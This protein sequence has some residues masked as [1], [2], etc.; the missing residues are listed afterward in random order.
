MSRVV[1]LCPGRGSYSK[2][3]L[4]CLTDIESNKLDVADAVRRSSG[5]PTVR[6]MDA[7]AKFRSS[8]HIAGENASLLTAGISGADFDQIHSKFDIVGICGNSMGW[9][10]ALGLANACSFKTAANLIETM[11]QYQ[12]RNVIGGQMVYSLVNDDWTVNLERIELVNQLVEEIPDCHWSIRLGGQAILGGTKEAL[13]RL[14]NALPPVEQSGRT[15]PFILPLHSAFHTPLML[16][17]HRQA[18]TDLADLELTTP[19]IPLIDGRGHI[20]RPKACDRHALKSY[21]LGKQVTE[22]YDFTAMMQSVLKH[23]APDHIILLGPGSNLGGAVAHVLIQERWQ[24]IRN[25]MDFIKRQQE[26]PFILAMGRPDQRHLV[27]S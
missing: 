8:W 22:T 11:G 17:T 6:E 12:H 15:F 14:Q 18:L 9:Y 27:V 10:T 23:I 5:R 3:T 26:R 7:S 2:D 25:K 4:S 1:V 19:A 13:A 20:W 16:D 21:T 24:G